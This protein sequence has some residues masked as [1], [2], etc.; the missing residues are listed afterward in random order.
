MFET[1]QPYNNVKRTETSFNRI[2]VTAHFF[3]KCL[4]MPTTQN[5]L[6]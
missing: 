4:K 2:L 1:Y 6:R 3:V 5:T